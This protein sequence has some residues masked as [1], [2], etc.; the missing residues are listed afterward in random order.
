[1]RSQS[2]GIGSADN[3]WAVT[4]RGFIAIGSTGLVGT[5]RISVST[6]LVGG[7]FPA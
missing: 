6:R 5:L 1:M 3:G 4:R 7:V 2:K